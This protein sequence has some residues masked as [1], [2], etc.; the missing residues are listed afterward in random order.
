[1][2]RFLMRV[3]M[4]YP[5]RDAEKTMIRERSGSRPLGDVERVLTPEALV[6]ARREVRSVH[7]DDALLNYLL[8]IVEGTRSHPDLTLG[9]SPRASLALA[10]AA[11]AAAYLDARD[12]V[13]PDDIK[14]LIEPV[15]A[16][17]LALRDPAVDPAARGDQVRALLVELLERTPVPL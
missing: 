13:A 12:F 6:A 5:Q 7:L 10:H 3:S 17:R 14:T 11:Q 4:G 1:M 9:A 8:Q 15:L 2:D 16:H